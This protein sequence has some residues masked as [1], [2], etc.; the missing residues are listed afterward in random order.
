LRESALSW[1]RNVT[2]VLS[3]L[4]WFSCQVYYLICLQFVLLLCCFGF[5]FVSFF[6]FIK[7]GDVSLSFHVAGFLFN[8]RLG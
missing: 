3:V 4:S 1:L 2:K 6:F 5:V 8:D 7:I